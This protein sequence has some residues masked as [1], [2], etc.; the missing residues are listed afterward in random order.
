MPPDSL[1]IEYHAS[2]ACGPSMKQASPVCSGLLDSDVAVAAAFSMSIAVP[3]PTFLMR[4][5][6]RS[7]FAATTAVDDFATTIRAMYSFS[8]AFTVQP[9]PLEWQH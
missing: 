5:L 8:H 6:L 1:W 9:M 4:I 2:C 7:E 3:V